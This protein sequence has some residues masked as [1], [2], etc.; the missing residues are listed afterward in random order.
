MS[1]PPSITP[2][3]SDLNAQRAR[4]IR[5]AWFLVAWVCVATLVV[6][7]VVWFTIGVVASARHEAA[8]SGQGL[9]GSKSVPAPNPDH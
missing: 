3:K 4:E 7:M 6:Y 5:K 9:F 8:V 1:Q 2:R